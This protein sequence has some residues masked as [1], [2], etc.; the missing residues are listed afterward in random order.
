V[1][2]GAEQLQH[3]EAAVQR[4]RRLSPDGAARTGAELTAGSSHAPTVP[5]G[6]PR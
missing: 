5:P 4:L 1:L 6:M 2:V 3:G